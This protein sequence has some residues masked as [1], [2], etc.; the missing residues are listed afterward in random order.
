MNDP[1]KQITIP[2]G[3]LRSRDISTIW[4]R[5]HNTHILNYQGDRRGVGNIKILSKN[6]GQ[7]VLRKLNSHQSVK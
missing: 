2:A 5:L 1:K 4:K 3:D 6:K 7:L